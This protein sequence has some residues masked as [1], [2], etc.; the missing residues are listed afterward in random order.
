MMIPPSLISAV[1]KLATDLPLEDY[2]DWGMPSQ[3]PISIPAK[4]EGPFERNVY[5]KENLMAR[6]DVA[7]DLE[8]CF[9][10]IQDW[11]GIGG[12]K[13]NPG[14]RQRISDFYDRLEKGDLTRDLHSVLP[15]LSKLAA[16]RWPDRYSIYD[17]RAVYALNWLLYCH[18]EDPV[19]F[20]Q[21]P[22]RSKALVEID[23]Q[24]L[25]RLADRKYSVR[26][27]KTAYFEYCELLTQLACEALG[28]KRPYYAEMLL[29]VA[30]PEWVPNDIRRR[31]SVAVST[32][33]PKAYP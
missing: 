15:S 18:T 2:Y 7:P 16:F 12:F 25:Y 23:T 29:F 10:V 20:P 17:S 11:G 27:H 19:L 24:T 21:P 28:Q 30:A 6:S 5:L 13:D 32:N 33:T 9:W 4:I 26:K 22:A 8:T 1:R 31:T 3:L 14:N